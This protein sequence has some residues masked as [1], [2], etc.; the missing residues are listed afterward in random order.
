[1]QQLSVGIRHYGSYPY[2]A[3]SHVRTGGYGADGAGSASLTARYGKRNRPSAF[4][5]G[6]IL[7][8]YGKIHFQRMYLL[9]YGYSGGR[10]YN[11]AYADAADA[12]DSVKR[13]DDFGAAQRGLLCGYICV[14]GGDA[15]LCSFKILP[16][17]AAYIHQFFLALL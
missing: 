6:V 13:S 5:Q 4:Q 15:R 1:C 2:G 7:Y 11:S 8:G 12:Y 10:G 14:Y 17:D 3:R 9:Q 16:A